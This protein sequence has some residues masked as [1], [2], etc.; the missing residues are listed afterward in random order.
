M[1]DEQETHEESHEETHEEHHEGSS[2]NDGMRDA[3]D[4]L[5]QKFDELT[6]FVHS[7]LEAK[8]SPDE[9][10]ASRPWTHKGSRG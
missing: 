3:F 2:A 4:A 9:S 7:T 5:S 6:S 10:P 1:D 8:S